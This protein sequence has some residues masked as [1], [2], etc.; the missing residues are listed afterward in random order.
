MNYVRY[1]VTIL[2]KG[3]FLLQRTQ[4]YDENEK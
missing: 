3:L 4:R 2:A 1:A